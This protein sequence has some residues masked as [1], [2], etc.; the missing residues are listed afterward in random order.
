MVSGDRQPPHNAGPSSRDLALP[1]ELE[2]LLGRYERFLTV[3]RGRSVHTARAYLSDVRALLV[4]SRERTSRPDSFDVGSIDLAVLRSWLASM[5]GGGAARTSVARRAASARGFTAWLVRTG[6]MAQDPGLRLRSPKTV[7]PLP[8]VLRQGQAEEL[9]TVAAREVD[10]AARKVR[11]DDLP[12]RFAVALALRDRAMVEVLYASGIRVSELVG[13]DVGD[14]DDDRRTLL[15]MGKGAR[16]RVVPFGV[17]AGR[18]VRA[19]SDEGRPLLARA[20][21]PAALFLGARGGR[22]GVRQVRQVVHRLVDHVDGAPSMG[23]HGMRHSAA[24]HLLDGGADLR[25]VQEVLGHASLATTQI[26]THV[27][28]ERLRAGYRQAHPRA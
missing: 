15:V 6:R 19:W 8:A 28:I 22:I 11:G 16:E 21:S 9:M 18:A 1:R 17:P 7:R 3:E 2:E 5:T 14:V 25:S 4:F 20:E 12:D 26:Y 13:L 10:G 23:P 24:T 27:S